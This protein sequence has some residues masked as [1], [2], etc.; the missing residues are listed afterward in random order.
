VALAWAPATVSAQATVELS[1]G[2]TATTDVEMQEP[3]KAEQDDEFEPPFRLSLP[4]I[5]DVEAWAKKGFRL[6]LG[7]S[8]GEIWGLDG[9][10]SGSYHGANVRAGARLD[11]DW[12]IMIGL[13]YNAV[14]DAIGEPQSTGNLLGLRFLGTVQ[15]ELYLTE[16]WTVAIGAGF[17]GIVEGFGVRE[18]KRADLSGSIVAPYTHPDNT[19]LLP[20]CEGVGGSA[21]LRSSYFF[22]L[23]P[24]SSIGLTAQ[25]DATWTA[26]E[27]KLGRTEPDTA[28]PIFRR[29]YWAHVGAHAGLMVGWR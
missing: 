21:L 16:R 22:V 4:T 7:Y 28:R 14:A 3:K 27:Q 8:M 25:V 12:A 13:S 5:A 11:A 1:R 19:A 29:Q 6:Q 20:R 17:G 15:P 24:L 9:A 23:G 26:C 18:D 10:P 2:T